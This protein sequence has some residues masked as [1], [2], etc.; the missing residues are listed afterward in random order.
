MNIQREYFN[1]GKM[2]SSF[3]TIL[4]TICFFV[5]SSNAQTNPN[6]KLEEAKGFYSSQ[7][8]DKAIELLEE[9]SQ[10]ISVDSEIRKESFRILGRA[11]VAKGLYQ[12]A[13]DAILKLLELE[14]PIIAFNPDYEPPPLMKVYYEARKDFSGSLEVERSDPGIKTMAIIDFKNRSIDQKLKFDPMEKGFSDLFIH[15]LN[16]STEL[17]VIERERIQW[18]FD[19]INIQDKFNMEGAVRMGKQ[20][21]VH[22][23]LLGSFIVFDDEIW[24]GARLVKVETSEILLTDEIKGEV[25]S[26]YELSDKLC[27]NIAEKID[28]NLDSQ[29][30]GVSSETKSLEAILLYSEGLSLIEMENYEEAYN[31]FLKALEY[32]P[33]YQN[34]KV[35]AESIKPLIG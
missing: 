27:Q 20:L 31:K 25:N 4:L 7:Y 6:K 12:E 3:I 13:K 21:G 17:K 18:I 28:V 10:D 9:L 11:Y 34:A 5:Y 14:P 23:V 35:K 2:Q 8:F 30:V 33:S 26:F 32:D 15:R 19:E 1:S 22:I 16:N 24:L 29:E